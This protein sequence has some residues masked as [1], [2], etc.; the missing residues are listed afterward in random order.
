MPHRFSFASTFVNRS[1]IGSV[2]LAV[3]LIFFAAQ[4]L[5]TTFLTLP[6]LSVFLLVAF[7]SILRLIEIFCA[8]QIVTKDKSSS[9][10]FAVSSISWTLVL[11]L[12]LA[13]LTRQ[14]DTHYF[15]ML[16]LPVLEAAI[17][18]SFAITLLISAA[19]SIV[20]LFWVAY[21]ANFTPPFESG[22][23]LEAS[24][25]VLVY[26]IVGCLVWLL[27]HMLRDREEQLRQQL[28]DLEATRGKLIE[29]EKLAAIGRLASAVAH[30]IRNPVAIISSA[31][32]TAA[33]G[34]FASKEREEM[35]RIAG[36]EAKRLEKLTTDFLSYAG[37]GNASFQQLDATALVGYIVSIVQPQ[38]LQKDLQ[39]EV[40]MCDTCCVYGNEGQLQQALLNLMR[41]AIEASPQSRSILVAVV[42]QSREALNIRIENAGPPIPRRV[43]DHIFEPFF[44]AKEGGTGLG[45]AIARSIVDRHHGELH[46]E[47]NDTDHI[48]FTIR[49]PS[50]DREDTVQTHT[51]R[52]F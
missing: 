12:L 35:S 20:S 15:G 41:N 2:Y 48:V 47:R 11:A 42:K 27:V 21:A 1:I 14:P 43:A 30:E 16:I 19:A 23:I 13:V 25:L 26:F 40:K 32:E 45:L 6:P 33:S 10:R 49:V 8:E 52:E 5:F 18:F 3:L 36:M 34:S 51:V 9:Q 38:A 17:Y 24:T 46:L 28:D 31:L 50:I 29:E 7:A 4:M 37:P 22:E 44:T 39:I